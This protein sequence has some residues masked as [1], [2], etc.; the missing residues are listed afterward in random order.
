MAEISGV[1][2]V[3]AGHVVD[4]TADVDNLTPDQIAQLLYERD[5]GISICH[6]CA[7]DIDDPE[8]GDLAGFTVDGVEYV[9]VDG[10]WVK[11]DV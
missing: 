11:S 6:Q 7:H 5:P 1:F 10:E 9:L 8:P 4:F 3:N 2:E